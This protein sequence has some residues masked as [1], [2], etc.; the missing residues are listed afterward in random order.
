MAQYYPGGGYNVNY[1]YGQNDRAVTGTISAFNQ[2]SM[3]LQ[4]NGSS[5]RDENEHGRHHNKNHENNGR[6]SQNCGERD[7]EG[8]RDDCDEHD[9]NGRWNSNNNNGG[10]NNGGYNTG[11]YNYG[12]LAVHLHQGTIINPTGTTLRPGM[13]VRIVGHPNGDGTFEADRIDV[14]NSGYRGY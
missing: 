8:E 1:G 6:W 10:W 13:N 11:N 7:D 14:A 2:F 4:T 5:R 3:T 12:G 9:N